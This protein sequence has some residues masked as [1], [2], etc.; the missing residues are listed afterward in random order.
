MPPE[1]R[2]SIPITVFEPLLAA[3]VGTYLRTAL[4]LVGVG[5]SIGIG[6]G[7]LAAAA[8]WIGLK[9][10]PTAVDWILA[11]RLHAVLGLGSMLIHVVLLSFAFDL[12]VEVRVLSFV[13]ILGGLGVW[14]AGRRRHA[15][16]VR[17]RG[18]VRAS[19]VGRVNRWPAILLSVGGGVVGS[20]LIVGLTGT[21]AT[22]ADYLFWVALYAGFVVTVLAIGF[23]IERSMKGSPAAVD[24]V[25]LDEALVVENRDAF[26]SRV[27]PWRRIHL[28]EVDDDT[29]CVRSRWPIGTYEC[30]L[31]EVPDSTTVVRVFRN[32]AG[33]G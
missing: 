12:L 13:P 25:A 14:M 24:L 17:N 3:L 15:S 6:A 31:S 20:A 19:V 30:D 28:D 18:T 23:G 1:S 2:P 33:D 26:G 5:D 29:L 22:V 8:V 27:I 32:R 7:I 11:R 4:H 21:Y 10:F 16:R 9:H